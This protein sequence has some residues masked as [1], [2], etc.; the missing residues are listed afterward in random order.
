MC[1]ALSVSE[2]ISAYPTSGGLYFTCK[3]LA[4]EKWVS[5]IS[6]I[7]GWINLLGQIAGV[8]SAEYGA[9]QILLAAVSMGSDFAYTPT[10]GHTIAVMAAI[11]ISHGMINSLQTSALEKLVK[12]YVTFHLGVLFSACVALLVMTKEKHDSTYVFTN[13]ASPSGWTP[14]GFAFLFGCLPVSWTLTDYD[15]LGHI[16]EEIQDPEIKAPWAISGAIGFTYVTGWL[17]TIVLVY[18]MGDPATILASPVGQP[19][20]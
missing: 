17:F 16:A 7:C 3:Y 8:A 11:T 15:S 5:E 2:L 19:V 6:W 1:I 10:T 18:C 13:V 12:V 14:T 4:P 20:A 9:A